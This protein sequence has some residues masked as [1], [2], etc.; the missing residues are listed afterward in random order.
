MSRPRAPLFAGL[1]IGLLL[2]IAAVA[3]VTATPAST[4][5]SRSYVFQDLTPSLTPVRPVPTGLWT[6]N[7]AVGAVIGARGNYTTTPDVLNHAI[8]NLSLPADCPG[9][10]IP[11][12]DVL[13]LSPANE[14]VLATYE[15]NP[16]NARQVVSDNWEW[17][18][19]KPT[20][21]VFLWA[22]A[23]QTFTLSGT[24]WITLPVFTPGMILIRAAAWGD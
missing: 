4:V 20:N 22:S 14:G 8:F 2:L 5:H 1:A 3:W 21:T 7:P 18:W 11:V 10:P 16:S 6:A 15:L 9:C 17:Y 23:P 19:P 12:L 13:G 24:Q